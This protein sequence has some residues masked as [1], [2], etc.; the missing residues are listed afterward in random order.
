MRFVLFFSP[1]CSQSKLAS[2]FVDPK[3][4]GNLLFVSHA[5]CAQFGGKDAEKE[6]ILCESIVRPKDAGDQLAPCPLL[7]M[8]MAFCCGPQVAG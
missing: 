6:A 2:C 3:K 7:Q 4:S 5:K 8:L 1:R